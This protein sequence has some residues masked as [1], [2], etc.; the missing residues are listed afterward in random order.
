[1]RVRTIFSISSVAVL[2]VALGLFWT[3]TASTHDSC[4][5]ATLSI[6]A[7]GEVSDYDLTISSTLGGSVHAT[8]DGQEQTIGPGETG[9]IS[10]VSAATTIDLAADP[11]EDYRFAN[12]IGDVDTIT[13]ANAPETT[14][15]V[16][17]H[18]FITATFDGPLPQGINWLLIGGILVPIVV[19]LVVFLV[20]R[21]RAA[22]GPTPS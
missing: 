11:K 3:A 20:R 13:N 5:A 17:G 1:M 15:T 4:E 21:K 2:S 9:T 12:W 14:I 8:F 6:T 18:H 22:Q 10:G 19:G 16:N 7:T